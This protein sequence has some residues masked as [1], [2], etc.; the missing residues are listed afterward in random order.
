M[1]TFSSQFKRIVV[2]A[3]LG[4]ASWKIKRQAKVHN[5]LMPCKENKTHNNLGPHLMIWGV[6]ILWYDNMF[7]LGERES[8]RP[9]RAEGSSSLS[10]HLSNAIVFLCCR[11]GWDLLTVRLRPGQ[12]YQLHTCLL[13]CQWVSEWSLAFVRVC[14]GM[15]CIWPAAQDCK[16]S[17]LVR[18]PATPGIC[19]YSS[20][21]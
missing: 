14:C 12:L 10:S 6:V 7:K 8:S 13:G 20:D 18:A 3:Q 17:E 21:W 16:Q 11:R 2:H 15:C 5:I 9:K 4:G 1:I 19:C